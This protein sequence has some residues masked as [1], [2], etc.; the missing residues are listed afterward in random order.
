[1]RASVTVLVF[2]ATLMPARHADASLARVTIEHREP[3]AGG[4][5]WGPAGPYERLTG[6]AYFEV[7]PLDPLNA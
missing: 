6:T 2:A 4:V 3:F 5:E 1:M 7:D